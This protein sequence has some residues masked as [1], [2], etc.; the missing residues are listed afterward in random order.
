MNHSFLSDRIVPRSWMYPV[1]QMQWQ[2]LLRMDQVLR[3]FCVNHLLSR[4]IGIYF[5]IT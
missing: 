2:L 3:V 5:I 4:K 1:Y